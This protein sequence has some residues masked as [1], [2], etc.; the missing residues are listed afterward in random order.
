M[1]LNPGAGGV[2]VK[3]ARDQREKAYDVI[4]LK[5]GSLHHVPA[6]KDD[7]GQK[8]LKKARSQEVSH[9]SNENFT[10]HNHFSFV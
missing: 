2:K 6:E 8:F 9:Q 7:T 10:L 4:N 5:P 1:P 3:A